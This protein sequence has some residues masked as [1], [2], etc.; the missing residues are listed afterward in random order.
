VETAKN[1]G[2]IET[3]DVLDNDESS[4]GMSMLEY[5]GKLWGFRKS[6]LPLSQF[7][8]QIEEVLGTLTYS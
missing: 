1:L 6:K 8:K 7:R 3:A 5:S 4:K 2:L